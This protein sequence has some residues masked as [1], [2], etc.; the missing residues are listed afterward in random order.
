MNNRDLSWLLEQ[1]LTEI[2]STKLVTLAVQDALKSDPNFAKSFQ[3]SLD[4]LRLQEQSQNAAAM[5]RAKRVLRGIQE[6]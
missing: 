6:S 5:S 2:E 3:Q 1:M 4:R